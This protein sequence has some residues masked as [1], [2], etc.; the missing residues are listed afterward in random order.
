MATDSVPSQ[1]QWQLAYAWVRGHEFKSGHG[2]TVFEAVA[3][4]YAYGLS[5]AQSKVEQL[6]K[7]NESLRKDRDR[8]A[9]E[10]T[11]QWSRAESAT[12]KELELRTRVVK[13]LRDIRKV[14][15]SGRRE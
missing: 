3:E 10:Y 15:R 1:E 8:F 6:Q 11:Q 4:A 2:D 7:E 5:N 13:G 14:L 9:N 12:T